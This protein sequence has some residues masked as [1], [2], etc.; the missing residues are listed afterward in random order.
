MESQEELHSM[1]EKVFANGEFLDFKGF[2]NSV[3]NISSDMFLFILIFLFE[4]RP[5]SKKTLQTHEKSKSPIQ[6]STNKFSK[7][8]ILTTKNKLIASPNMM[9]KFS[10]TI[11]LSRSPTMLKKALDTNPKHNQLLRNLA[12]VQDKDS[13]NVLKN[14]SVKSGQSDQIEEGVV[15]QIPVYR[16]DRNN[17]SNI[18]TNDSSKVSYNSNSG[19]KNDYT[20]LN[21]LPAHKYKTEGVSRMSND[22]LTK[23]TKE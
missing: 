12:G 7:S 14:Y 3:E 20:D 2:Q 9:S 4:Q 8:P 11:A 19:N 21:I 17:L 16:K 22:N 6:S 10:P 23:I 5:F 13:K 1:L 18:N 15:A